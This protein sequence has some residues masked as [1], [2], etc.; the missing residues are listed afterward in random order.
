LQ[1]INNVEGNNVPRYAL[2]LLCGKER[3][4]LQEFQKRIEKDERISDL[5]YQLGIQACLKAEYP[6][7][8]WNIFA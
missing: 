7:G 6:D 2:M 1:L 5:E 4:M 8:M 3:N